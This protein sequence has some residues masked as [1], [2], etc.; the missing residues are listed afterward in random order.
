MMILSK[1]I[2]PSFSGGVSDGLAEWLK[3]I[4]KGRRQSEGK[5]L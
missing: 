2:P 5:D 1:H 3:K 4:S